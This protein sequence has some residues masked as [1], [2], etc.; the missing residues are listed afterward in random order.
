[1]L[2]A[3]L[4]AVALL[5]VYAGISDFRE[6]RIPNWIPL[7]IFALY[8]AFLAGQYLLELPSP[9]LPLLGSLGVGAGVA[10][11]FGALFA[12]KYLGGGDVKLIAAMGFWAGP[13]LILPFLLLMALSGGILALGF[14]AFDW[15]SKKASGGQKGAPSSNRERK[16]LKIPYG[17]AIAAAGLF[18]VNNILTFLLA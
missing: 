2:E 1:M 15:A 10:V 9:A 16:K 7:S 14:L 3:I 8:A 6:R 18:V 11:V 17:I 13:G 12:L 4:A 5:L